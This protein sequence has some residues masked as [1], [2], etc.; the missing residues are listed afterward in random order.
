M[1]KLLHFF[2]LI[3]IEILPAQDV[4]VFGVQLRD[5]LLIEYAAHLFLLSD[6][7]LKQLI[8]DISRFDVELFF[9]FLFKTVE[10]PVLS[11]PYRKIFR[12]IGRIDGEEPEAFIQR[13]QDRK[14]TR[15]D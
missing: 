14:S 10:V 2:F 1:K 12:Q 8:Q 15:L 4:D 6:D 9:G 5:D 3:G 11:Y 13:M 7:D